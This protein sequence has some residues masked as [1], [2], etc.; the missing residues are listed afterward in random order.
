MLK[1]CELP[2][3][4]I[5]LPWYSLTAHNILH[6]SPVSNFVLFISGGKC[7]RDFTSVPIMSVYLAKN[8][9]LSSK[10]LYQLSTKSKNDLTPNR[11]PFV[12][13]DCFHVKCPFH[14]NN[15]SSIA[16][17]C[18]GVYNIELSLIHVIPYWLDFSRFGIAVTKVFVV[19]KVKK[20]INKL[21]F[22]V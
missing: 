13:I 10:E 20:F 17:F 18:F 8:R 21:K 1:L 16:I 7:F 4:S 2:C 6:A 14:N 19:D 22:I 11:A 12:S 3:L 15:D 5:S 9:E